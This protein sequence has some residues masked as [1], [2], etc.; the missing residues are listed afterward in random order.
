MPRMGRVVLPN[1]PHHVVQRGHN[2][3]VVF[4]GESDFQRYLDDVR[5]LKAAFGVQVYAY[6]LMTNHVHL[7]LCPGEAIAGLGQMMKS[8]AA[9]ATRYRNKLEGRSGTLWESRYKSSP[10]QTELYLLACMRYI[11]LNPVRAAMVSEP[12]S[13]VWSSYRQHA[14]ID[15]EAWI[16]YDPCYLGLGDIDSDRG[17]RYGRFVSKGVPD[18]ERSLICQALQR[19]QL[20]GNDRFVDDVEKIL[21][22]RVEFRAQGRPGKADD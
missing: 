11:E 16:D 15:A 17:E 10:V 4:A 22:R 1:Y 5:E 3:Q 19:G 9:R 18:K 13:Y 7:L 2:R 8:L 20:T 14:G 21:G 12:D 6:C